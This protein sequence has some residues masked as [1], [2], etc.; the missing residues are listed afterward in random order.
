MICFAAQRL[1]L[2]ALGRSVDSAWEQKKP[3][4]RKMLE[5][6]AVP[7]VQCITLAL[8][9]CQGYPG[10]RA[11]RFVRGNLCPQFAQITPFDT[12]KFDL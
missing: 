1:A 5:N 6:A 4:A 8:G 12:S 10:A 3:E 7:S 11:G 2:L 9:Q